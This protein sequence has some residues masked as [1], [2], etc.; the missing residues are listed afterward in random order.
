MHST[1]N[2]TGR[3]VINSISFLHEE[4]HLLII[5]SEE[6]I[7]PYA[8]KIINIFNLYQHFFHFKG[9]PTPAQ[10]EILFHHI[11]TNKGTSQDAYEIP[12][13]K[14]LHLTK[15]IF[16]LTERNKNH[17][18]FPSLSVHGKM[19]ATIQDPPK[20][21]QRLNIPKTKAFLKQVF[22]TTVFKS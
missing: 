12:T 18:S 6:G 10:R 13:S 17:R 11:V 7:S 9:Y 16:I 1:C 2:V 3:W 4:F 14:W 19:N 15:L 20:V 21:L 8:K 5:I 22:Q